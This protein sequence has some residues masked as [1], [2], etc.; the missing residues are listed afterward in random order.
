VTIW[1]A[2]KGYLDSLPLHEVDAWETKLINDLRLRNK[3]LLDKINKNKVLDEKL[4]EEIGKVVKENTE[5][6]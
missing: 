2:S 4:E 3:K 5:K 6:E 1:A